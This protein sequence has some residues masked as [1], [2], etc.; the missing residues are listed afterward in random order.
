M[1]SCDAWKGQT[2]F[3]V[4]PRAPVVALKARRLSQPAQPEEDAILI[5]DST[6]RC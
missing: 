5:L 6:K 4:R 2:L 3:R 1:I